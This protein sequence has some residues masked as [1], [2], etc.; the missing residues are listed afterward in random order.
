MTLSRGLGLPEAGSISGAQGAQLSRRELLGL[1]IPWF[2]LNFPFAALLPVVIPAQILLFIAPGSTGNAAQA[3]FLAVM[4]AFG[5]GT[6]LVLQPLIGALSDRTATRLGRRRPYLLAGAIGLLTGLVL[7]AL[8]HGLALFLAGLFLVVVANTV[9][10]TAC[11]GLVPDCVPAPQRGAASGVIGVM[12]LLGTVGSLGVA[13]L[14]LSSTG[15]GAAAAG[16]I[17]HGTAIYYAVAAGVVAVFV[18]IPL[19]AVKENALARRCRAR[20][21]TATSNPEDDTHATTHSEAA[22]AES[23]I[24]LWLTPWRHANFRWVFLTRAFVMLGLALFM[25][26]IEYYFARV[27][28]IASFVQT[29]A[30]IAIVSLVGA[31]GSTVLMGVISDRIGRRTPIV[32]VASACMAGAAFIFV[33]APGQLPLWP[34][35]ILFGFGY[36]AYLSVDTAL[37]VDALPSQHAAG[38]GLGLFSLASTLPGVL[39]PLMGGVV[40]VL[41]SS[42]ADTALG[43]RGVFALATLFLILG[44]GLVLKVREHRNCGRRGSGTS[45]E[46]VESAGAASLTSELLASS[47]S[48]QDVALVP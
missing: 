28:H 43:Y 8:T 19:V 36:G 42:V 2:A 33:V 45:G 34:L 9:S 10:N 25:T 3:L 23:L 14:L 27:A 30:V 40:I 1:G 11:Q 16:N 37:A 41:A 13:S 38:T 35:G 46:M 22:R 12:T 24:S 5:A 31:V 44:A 47:G 48:E 15:T 21:E 17:A 32:C 18:S 20:G 29:T 7:L 4:V 6:A 26:Y 39:A